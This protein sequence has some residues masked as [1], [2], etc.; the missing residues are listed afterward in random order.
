MALDGESVAVRRE[1]DS[2]V[3]DR[4]VRQYRPGTEATFSVWRDGKTIELPVKLEREPAPTAEMFRWEDEQLEF[5]ARE[6][7][8]EDMARMQ[9]SPGL[10]AALISSVVPAGWAA[11]AG[12]RTNDLVLAADGH[13]ISSVADLKASREAAFRSKQQWWVLEVQRARESLFVE[14][15][16]KPMIE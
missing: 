8:F 3:F 12:L 5:E 11:L 6:L 7:A 9:L 2:E 10:K 13:P 4:Q 1:E 15:N 16:L 14:I